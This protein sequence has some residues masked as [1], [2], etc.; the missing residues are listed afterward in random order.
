MPIIVE[1]THCSTKLKVPDS[2]MGTSLKCPKCSQIFVAIVDS[3]SDIEIVEDAASNLSRTTSPPIVLT[4]PGVPESQK[5]QV[6]T[7]RADLQSLGPQN[8]QVIVNVL[9]AAQATGQ[10]SFSVLRAGCLAVLGLTLASLLGILGVVFMAQRSLEQEARKKE[11]I[12]REEVAVEEKKVKEFEQTSKELDSLAEEK[13]KQLDQLKKDI[14]KPNQ[15][16][17][18][19]TG[20]P[21]TGIVTESTA[22]KPQK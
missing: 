14:Q 13:R 8:P 7:T 21:L 3:G 17:L 12:L 9:P 2:R 5:T 18:D 6:L 1:C 19:L 15:Q 10:K 16:W 20:K 22:M 11:Q 4:Q